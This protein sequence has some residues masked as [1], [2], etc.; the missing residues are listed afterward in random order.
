MLIKISSG[1]VAMGHSGGGDASVGGDLAGI[2]RLEKSAIRSEIFDGRGSSEGCALLNTVT[3]AFD[4]FEC[5]GFDGES[6]SADVGK[7]F[8]LYFSCTL[9]SRRNAFR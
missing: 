4:E 7:C 9:A 5:T 1:I 6:E 3:S 2:E 8:F